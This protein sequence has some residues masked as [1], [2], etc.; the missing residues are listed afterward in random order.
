VKGDF[1]LGLQL[2]VLNEQLEHWLGEQDDCVLIG[3]FCEIAHC[4]ALVDD[5]SANP[6]SWLLIRATGTIQPV[7]L[8]SERLDQDEYVVIAD[9]P[10]DA[11]A[12]D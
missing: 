7:L 2:Y 9:I 8:D 11:M 10:A 6:Y 12:S 3:R 1:M 4:S 5:G